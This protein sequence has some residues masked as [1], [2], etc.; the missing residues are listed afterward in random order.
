[1]YASKNASG[2][3]NITIGGT[4]A[5]AGQWNHYAVTYT[6]G[7]TMYGWING[8][9]SLSYNFS[10][11]YSIVNPLDT[12]GLLH[13]SQ[14]NVNEWSVYVDTV[15]VSAG[16]PYGSAGA[17]FTAPATLDRDANKVFYTRFEQRP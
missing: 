5:T 11:T 9:P 4:G 3:S 1:V 12:I 13:P 14:F 10:S 15:K 6:P 7:R 2:Q 17:S 16:M 8:V